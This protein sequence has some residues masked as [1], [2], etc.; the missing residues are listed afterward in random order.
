MFCSGCVEDEGEPV[1]G[2][3]VVE[4]VVGLDVGTFVV[5]DG[6]TGSDVGDG[7]L[8]KFGS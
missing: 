2:D 8:F 7:V 3:A 4:A 5:G 6:V 1:T